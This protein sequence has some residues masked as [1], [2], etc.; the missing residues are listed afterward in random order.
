M[1]IGTQTQFSTSDVRSTKVKVTNLDITTA[2]IQ[3]SH[4]LTSDL[5]QIMVRSR[6]GATI[7]YCWITGETNTNFITIER[8]A[9]LYLN[10]LAFTGKVLFI[11]TD[12][13]GIV[14]IQELY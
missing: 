14:E 6:V 2:D 3:F 5:K 13:T 7:Q 9:V 12:I 1:S 11:Q 4:T 8:N 10:D